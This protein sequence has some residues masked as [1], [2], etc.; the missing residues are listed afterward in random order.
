MLL[1]QPTLDYFFKFST[2]H[3]LHKSLMK[4]RKHCYITNLEI[5]EV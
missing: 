2:N 5:V 3:D 4:Q 1:I